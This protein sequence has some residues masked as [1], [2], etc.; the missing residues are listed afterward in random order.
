MAHRILLKTTIAPFDDNWCSARFSLLLVHLAGLTAPDGSPVYDV[1]SRDRHQDRDGSDPDLLALPTSDT[2]EL[3]LFAVE[4]DGGLSDADCAAIRAFRARGGGCMVT[5]DHQD[6]GAS[7]LGLGEL[8]AAHFFQHR[9]PEPDPER[10]RVDDIDTP[11]ISWPNYHS[12]RNGDFQEIRSE[13]PV[14][15]LLRRADGQVICWLPAHPHEGAVGVPPD[16]AHARVVATGTSKTTGRRF[17]ITVA[18]ERGR[19]GKGRAVAQS[20]FH[21]FADYN[22]DPA[23]GCPS[24]VS[25]P[26]G[27]GMRGNPEARRDTETWVSNVARWL[28]PA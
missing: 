28:L 26:C 25:E 11:E 18:F 3:W 4:V 19:D 13:E 2:A 12:G 24:F 20:T 6:M 1:V 5:R 17:N 22:W 7:V 15:E 27:D 10:R 14:H 21:H 23:L 9:N 8:G 16:V